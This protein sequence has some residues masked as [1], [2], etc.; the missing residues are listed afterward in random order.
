MT[1]IQAVA[2]ATKADV[3]RLLADQGAAIAKAV[4]AQLAAD[5]VAD[6]AAAATLKAVTDAVDAFDPPPAPAPAA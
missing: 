2:T 6:D 4:A 3:D 1:D 5:G